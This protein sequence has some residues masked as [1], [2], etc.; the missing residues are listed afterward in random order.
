M[1]ETGRTAYALGVSPIGLLGAHQF[2]LNRP[3]YGL[4]YFFTFGNFG[5]GWIVDW[6]PTSGSRKAR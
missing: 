5:I 3:E 4:L 1:R 6:F 2:Y